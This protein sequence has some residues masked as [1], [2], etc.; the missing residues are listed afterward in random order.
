MLFGD[1]SDNFRGVVLLCFK[2]GITLPPQMTQ[3]ALRVGWI[4]ANA[5]N[6]RNFDQ[7]L[8]WYQA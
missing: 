1:K 6:V 3:W 7:L 4:G 8:G 2:V 5:E